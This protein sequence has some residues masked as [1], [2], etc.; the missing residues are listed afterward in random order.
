VI[1]ITGTALS[2]ANTVYLLGGFPYLL[3]TIPSLPVADGGGP[4]KALFNPLC[5][6]FFDLM[7]RARYR[8]RQHRHEYIAASIT[9]DRMQNLVAS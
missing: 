5:D 7:Q 4:S 1:G 3:V 8:H 9:M 2:I 6:S